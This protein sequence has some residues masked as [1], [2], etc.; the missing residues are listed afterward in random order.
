MYSTL[1]QLTKHPVFYHFAEISKIPRGSGNEKEIS[2]YLVKFAQDRNLEVVQ[3]EALNVII[4]KPATPGY[5]N[6][7]TIIIQG[8]MDMVCEKN[9]ATIHDFEKDPIELRIVGDMLYAKETTLGADNGIAVAYALALLDSTNIAHPALEVVITTEEETT[10]GGAF[11][12]DPKH[13]DGKIF[14]NID[15][16]EDHKL[17]VSSAG[18]AK[19]V[20]TISIIWDEAPA[21]LETYRLSVGGLKGGHSG[22]EID[23]QRGNANKVLGR[24]LYDL[25]NEVSLYISDIRGGLKTNA[26]PR[27]SA[28]TILFAKSDVETVEGKVEEWT[29]IL[30]EELRAVDPDVHV[31]LTKVEEKI[32]QVFAKETQKQLISSLFLIPNG[33]QSMSMDIKGLVES[34]TNLGVIETLQNEI[35]LKNEVRSSV[36]TLKQHIVNKIKHIAELVGAQFEKESEYPEWPYNPNSP[37][38]NLFEKVH[39]EKYNE[40]VEI[41][42]VHA[43]IECS[44]F[45]QKMPELDAISFGPD[46]FNVHTPDEH[47]S[48]SS[49]MNNWGYFIDVL[50]ETKEL[51]K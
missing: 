49:V 8:H 40:D 11:A 18:G 48:I 41:Y 23:K 47:I 38:R 14:I 17:L 32:N 42:A 37:I 29:R 26:I 5:E 12:V 13:F 45:V 33:I 39:Q 51:V 7:P 27:E 1:E 19:A 21:E 50:R 22:M 36:A 30:Q 34:S 15:S 9:E 3:D 43:G 16:E 24:V 28:A 25:S 31:S 44:V 10:M 46:I 4:K 20:E 6:V 35:K 2:D